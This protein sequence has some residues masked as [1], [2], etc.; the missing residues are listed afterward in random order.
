M[1]TGMTTPMTDERL[2]DFR[3]STKN[4]LS[5]YSTWKVRELT[6]EIVRLRAENEELREHN[7][8][9]DNWAR[10]TDAQREAA[11]RMAK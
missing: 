11:I 10:L 3:E 6:D 5:E 9:A 1:E 2:E 8:D 7:Q 4:P